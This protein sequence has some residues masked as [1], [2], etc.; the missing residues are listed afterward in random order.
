[1]QI[2][3]GG[4]A[5]DRHGLGP[6]R[7]HRD[8]RGAQRFGNV[9]CLGGGPGAAHDHAGR[10]GGGGKAGRRI[11]AQNQ[12]L[13]RQPDC[14]QAGDAIGGE[15]DMD[16]P[17]GAPFAI[18]AGAIHRIDDPHARF[19]QA[20]GR[21]LRFF[22]QHAV[23]RAMRRQ[24]GHQPGIG[25]GIALPAQLFAG[26]AA[27]V[28]QIDQQPASAFGQMDGQLDIVHSVMLPP[29][30][31]SVAARRPEGGAAAGPLSLGRPHAKDDHRRS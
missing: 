23:V 2:D 24:F 20:G 14:A 30:A 25:S 5:H 4:A 13:R 12:V 29:W 18:F 22:G 16:G 10:I 19:G 11:A 9:Q 26:K 15:A 6:G 1:M 28:A 27:A 3:I 8:Q 31:L 7:A 21:V 17:V